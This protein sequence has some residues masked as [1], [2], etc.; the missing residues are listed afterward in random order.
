MAVG[1]GDMKKHIGSTIAL[2]FGILSIVAGIAKPSATAIAGA[3]IVLGALAYRSAKKRKLGTVSN[4]KVRLTLEIIGIVLSILIVV[5]QN[6]L[7]S[8]IATDPVINFV[9]PLW[10]LIAYLVV[11]LRRNKS[12]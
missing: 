8:L 2:C 7:K 4:S 6:D 11:S 5:L 9:I 1:E 12:I 10:V 3:T